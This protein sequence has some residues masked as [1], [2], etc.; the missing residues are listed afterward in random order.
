MLGTVHIVNIR[1]KRLKGC[2][3]KRAWLKET[4]LA[5]LAAE[6][7]ARGLEIDCMLTDDPTMRAFNRKY[8]GIDQPTDVLSFALD[9]AGPA[10][11]AFP[12]VPGAPAGM[13][14]LVVSYPTALAQAARR[15]VSVEEE[16]RLLLVHGA[17]HLLGYDH[18]GRD[19]TLAMR[20]REK[21]IL[22]L[23]GRPGC[24]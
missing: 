18:A 17:L 20:R 21:Q 4:V 19:D 2:T 8:R 16:V 23:P 11:T 22:G 12:T 9:E 5:V 7:V 15:G 13:G 6:K 1:L 3:L 10:D 24:R 14:I